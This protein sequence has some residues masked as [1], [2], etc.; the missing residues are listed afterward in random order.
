MGPVQKRLGAVFAIPGD[1]DR[2]SDQFVPASPGSPDFSLGLIC[3]TTLVPRE[4]HPSSDARLKGISSVVRCLSQGYFIRCTT[5]GSRGIH[6]PLVKRYLLHLIYGMAVGHMLGNPLVDI[7]CGKLINN[8][9]TK[10]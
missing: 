10:R 7:D 3:C 2:T 1:C 6:S 8:K 9:I 4:S 5:L